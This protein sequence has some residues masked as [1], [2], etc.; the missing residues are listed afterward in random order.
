MTNAT[1]SLWKISARDL[2]SLLEK[3]EI[4]PEEVIESSVKRINQVNKST[5]A[6]VTLCIDRAKQK[7]KESKNSENTILK[8]IPV[9]IKDMTE[10]QGVKT[11]Y[12]SKLYANN[13]FSVQVLNF[14][15]SQN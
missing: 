6:I 9:L 4:S 7:I 14:Q 5:N 13:I 15:S 11:T 8:N 12:G 1:D 2:I 3:K 10:V